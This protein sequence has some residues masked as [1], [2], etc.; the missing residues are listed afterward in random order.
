MD[1]KNAIYEKD[2]EVKMLCEQLDA[3]KVQVELSKQEANSTTASSNDK[4]QDGERSNGH[5]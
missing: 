5:V 4:T 3:M 1:I 2:L